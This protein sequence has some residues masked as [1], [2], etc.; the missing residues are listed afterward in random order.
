MTVGRPNFGARKDQP[1]NPEVRP[2]VEAEEGVRELFRLV[3]GPDFFPAIERRMMV[4]SRPQ[5]ENY[6]AWDQVEEK[7]RDLA[8]EQRPDEVRDAI[9]AIEPVAKARARAEA[10]RRSLA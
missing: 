5:D 3:R 10:I 6:E 1:T 7:L 4:I 2:L 9:K 8:F